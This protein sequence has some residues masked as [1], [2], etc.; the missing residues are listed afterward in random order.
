MLL[1]FGPTLIPPTCHKARKLRALVPPV[2]GFTRRV[3]A[4]CDSVSTTSDVVTPSDLPYQAEAARWNDST[5]THTERSH[6]RQM[7]RRKV[8]SE[9]TAGKE[10]VFPCRKASPDTAWRM[11]PPKSCN[12]LTP[13]RFE[14]N[15]TIIGQIRKHTPE[16]LAAMLSIR[17]VINPDFRAEFVD[18]KFVVF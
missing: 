14:L 11:S 7:T 13:R 16:P 10:P 3:A 4:G 2:S 1:R 18:R 15:E 9:P 5:T 12:R 17:G 8:G 6:P